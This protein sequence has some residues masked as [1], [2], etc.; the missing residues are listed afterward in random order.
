MFWKQMYDAFYG[1]VDAMQQFNVSNTQYQNHIVTISFK[2]RAMSD[3][4]TLCAFPLL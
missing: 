4:I 1:W 3:E 2:M